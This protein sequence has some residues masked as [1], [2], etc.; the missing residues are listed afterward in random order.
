MVTHS[1]ILT[2]RIPRT[3]RPGGLPSVQSQSRTRLKRLSRHDGRSQHN[4]VNTF[5]IFKLKN[6][7]ETEIE[8]QMFKKIKSLS[9]PRAKEG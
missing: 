6:R 9:L 2:W 4:S 1:S 3:E 7:K 5:L 8:S